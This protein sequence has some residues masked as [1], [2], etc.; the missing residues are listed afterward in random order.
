[1]DSLV[2]VAM[3]VFLALAINMRLK[4]ESRLTTPVQ[5]S[6]PDT[7][8][9]GFKSGVDGIF[10]VRVIAMEFDEIGPVIYINGEF[11]LGPER[12]DID[13]VTAEVHVGGRVEN[14][15]SFDPSTEDDPGERKIGDLVNLISP[16]WLVP[17]QKG[18][19]RTPMFAP[20]SED[21][22]NMIMD[23]LDSAALR[24]VEKLDMEFGDYSLEGEFLNRIESDFLNDFVVRELA[25][26][27]K[28]ELIWRAGHMVVIVRFMNSYDEIVEELRLELDLAAKDAEALDG[29]IDNI[30]L[31]A[32]RAQLDLETINY[33]TVVYES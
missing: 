8:H 9:P 12:V 10:K 15:V 16:V 22:L 21:R 32:F 17:E 7:N 30:I 18:K 19:F 14:F 23:Q 11:S 3:G 4:D 2:W 33:S 6:E 26:D 27:I 25:S 29:N 1:M 28:K 20:D 31:N 24:M 13:I 5:L